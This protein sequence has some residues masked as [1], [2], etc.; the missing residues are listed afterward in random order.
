MLAAENERE[1]NKLQ[2]FNKNLHIQRLT[3]G[4]NGKLRDMQKASILKQEENT[5]EIIKLQKI[6]HYLES[7]VTV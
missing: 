4:S 1:W 5:L 7:N 3:R 6:I 2:G